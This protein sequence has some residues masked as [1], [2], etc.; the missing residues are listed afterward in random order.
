MNNFGCDPI[1]Q[2]NKLTPE[3]AQLV[4]LNGAKPNHRFNLHHLRLTI[5]RNQPPMIINDIDLTDFETENP[6]TISRRHAE[7]QWV[8]GSL[9]IV[10]LGSSN[11]TFVD[12]KALKPLGKNEPSNPIILKIGSKIKLGNLLLE[13]MDNQ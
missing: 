10:D 3:N 6:P 7:I 13:I 2:R 9:Q 1:P 5:G 11:G 12:G 8:E 4:I